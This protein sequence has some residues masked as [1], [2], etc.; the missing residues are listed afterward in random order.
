MK[1]R[2]L[3]VHGQATTSDLRPA[4]ASSELLQKSDVALEEQ[5]N[6]VDPIFQ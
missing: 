3:A 2:F 1:L 6:V 5:L 4:P